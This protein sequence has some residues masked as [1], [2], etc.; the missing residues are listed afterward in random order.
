MNLVTDDQIIEA[1]E[2]FWTEHGY[3]PSVRDLCDLTGTKSPSTMHERLGRLRRK[4]R[5]TF[6]NGRNRT[7]RVV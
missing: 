2:T 6:V 3:A 4:G 5:L 7:L 1:I